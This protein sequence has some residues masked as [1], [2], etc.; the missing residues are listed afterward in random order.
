MPCFRDLFLD[1][2]NTLDLDLEV[3]HK[4]KLESCMRALFPKQN[5]TNCYYFSIDG[6]RPCFFI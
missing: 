6:P 4:D 5:G 2:K 1:I 3:L